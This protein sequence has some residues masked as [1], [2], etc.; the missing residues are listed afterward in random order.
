M[1]RC[2]RERR[3]GK[4]ERVEAWRSSPSSLFLLKKKRS[5]ERANITGMHI[6]F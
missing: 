4:R 2:A 6:V 3:H 1:N 5:K